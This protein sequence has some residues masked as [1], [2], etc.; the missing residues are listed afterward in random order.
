MRNQAEPFRARFAHYQVKRNFEGK[1][2]ETM[3]IKTNV[4]AGGFSGKP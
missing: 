4:K 2:D 1:E 3:K